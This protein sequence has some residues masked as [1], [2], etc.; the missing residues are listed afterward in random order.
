MKRNFI[1]FLMIGIMSGFINGLLGTGGGII[2]V[3]FLVKFAK[4]KRINSHANAVCIVL[5][6]CIASSIFCYN[7][8]LFYI[9]KVWVYVI[10]G[11]IG[12]VLGSLLLSKINTMV[13]KKIFA[14]FSI[15]FAFRFLFK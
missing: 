3:P 8:K 5:F 15:W 6:L 13:L 2:I 4:L 9:S 1:I 12:S 14:C 11:L 10:S 7:F